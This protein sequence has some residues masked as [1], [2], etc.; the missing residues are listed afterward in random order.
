MAIP[1]DVEAPSER[2]GAAR[3]PLS[4]GK[5]EQETPSL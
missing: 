3:S 2:M 4:G 5:R 1:V